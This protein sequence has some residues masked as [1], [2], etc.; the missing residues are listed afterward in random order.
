[1]SAVAAGT[2]EKG[3]LVQMNARI[4]KPEWQR[5]ENW[6]IWVAVL[7]AAL[8]VLAPRAADSDRF[9]GPKATEVGRAVNGSHVRSDRVPFTALDVVQ[10][11]STV[12]E[13]S[14]QSG[15]AGT[16]VF[17]NH[18]AAAPEDRWRI[19]IS[20]ERKSVVVE[21]VV[22]GD[23][24]LSLAREFFESPLFERGESEQLYEMFGH[25]Q[26]SP[27]KKL[28]RFTVSMSF[29]ETTGQQQLVLRFAPPEEA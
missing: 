18:Q 11:F 23:Y 26:N 7:A 9:A 1:M 2:I 13:M 8:L 5:F 4:D 24:G 29:K 22:G 14:A 27:V 19:A 15:T 3:A 6:L 10:Y 21:F 12:L 20:V 17:E 28:A 25:A 16:M